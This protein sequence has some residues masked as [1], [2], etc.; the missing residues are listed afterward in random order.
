[1]KYLLNTIVA[2]LAFAG[3]AAFA[4][5]ANHTLANAR[6]LAADCQ[7]DQATLRAMCIG[8]LAAISDGV[9]QH[10]KV[11][12]A[13]RSVC[14]PR[15]VDLEA[16]RLALLQYVAKTPSAIEGHSFEVVQAALMAG[17]PCSG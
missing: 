5:H 13:K 10:Q 12:V 7:S 8:Y 3:D 9:E 2:L 11:G 4:D 14:V 16:Y 6:S 15:N 1:M 17:W